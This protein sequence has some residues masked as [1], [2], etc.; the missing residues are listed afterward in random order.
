MTKQSPRIGIISLGCPL[1]LVDSERILTQLGTEGYV[2]ADSYDDADVVLVNTCGFT[3]TARAESLGAIQEAA[4]ENSRIIVTGCLGNDPATIRTAAP[5]VLSITGPHQYDKVVAAVH[6]AVP[7]AH[8]P[9]KDLMSPEGLKFT[10]RHYSYLKISEGCSHPCAFCIVPELRGPLMNRPINDVLAEA[11][12]LVDSG[13]RELLVT[14][15]DTGAYDELLKLTEKLSSLNV[16][17][18]LHNVYPHPHID[19]IVQLMADGKTLPFLDIP[20]QHASPTVLK[21][22]RH[23]T[24]AE[25]ALKRIGRWRK[26]CPDIA[27]QSTFMVGFP[28][29]TEQD[30][31]TLLNFLE[32]AQ[33]DRVTCMTYENVH[34]AQANALSGHVDEDDK[35]SRQER[36]DELAQNISERK[37]MD[38]L[39]QTMLVLVDDVSETGATGR[40]YADSPDVGGKVFIEDAD[41]VRPGDFVQA[42]IT[43]SSAYD[44]WGHIKDEAE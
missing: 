15:H 22:M 18:R 27:I 20:F 30:F 10:P 41:G 3:D 8:G 25:N 16:W 24:Q 28:G 5:N 44:L 17:V 32:D 12:L 9:K 11:E 36:F 29:E 38:R 39:N 42:T 43:K 19:D 34:G 13:V 2:I 31:D 26:M 40:T 14:S 4:A 23:P 21:A 33:L 1:A 7:P 37:L 6:N 35:L